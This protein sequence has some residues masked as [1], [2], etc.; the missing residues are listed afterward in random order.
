MVITGGDLDQKAAGRSSEPGRICTGCGTVSE[1]YRTVKGEHM[2]KKSV[3]EKTVYVP[4][5]CQEKLT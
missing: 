4:I 2:A 5:L 1:F 3:L